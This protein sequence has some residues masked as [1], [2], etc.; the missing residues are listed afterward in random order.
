MSTPEILK[1]SPVGSPKTFGDLYTQIQEKNIL[2]P[3]EENALRDRAMKQYGML[4][5]I[6]KRQEAIGSNTRNELSGLLSGLPEREQILAKLD[7]MLPGYT[8]IESAKKTTE[9]A[10]NTPKSTLSTPDIGGDLIA[11]LTGSTPAIAATVTG[12]GA[13]IVGTGLITEK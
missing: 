6:A 9:Q 3:E 13:A 11:S 7:S 2:T 8:P 4:G 5:L 10:K 12:L 1:N